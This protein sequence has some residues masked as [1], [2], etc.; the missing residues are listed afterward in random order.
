VG[1]PPLVIPRVSLLFLSV[2]VRGVGCLVSISLLGWSLSSVPGKRG[3]DNK[4]D[5]DDFR[6]LASCMIRALSPPT[7][8]LPSRP[9]FSPADLLSVYRTSSSLATNRRRSRTPFPNSSVC[10]NSTHC[11]SPLSFLR[12][13]SSVHITMYHHQHYH[14][15]LCRSPLSSNPTQFVTPTRF[16]CHY[17]HPERQ[18]TL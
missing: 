11:S 4:R 9:L 2:C 15:S 17:K 12:F 13:H 6:N 7:L 18:Q 10:Y 1:E 14:P 16:I 5:R 3:L 8:L